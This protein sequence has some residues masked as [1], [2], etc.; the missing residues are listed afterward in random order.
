MCL[1]DAEV[2]QEECKRL[3]GHG[4][5]AIS[6]EAELSRQDVLA[7]AALGHKSLRKRGTFAMGNHPAHD[8]SAE[9][10]DDD[11]Q[12][13]VGPLLRPKQLGYVPAPDLV[14]CSC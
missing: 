14:W 2:G 5:T 12:V 1:V 11:V 9:Y 3:R 13:E 6:M 4:R 7:L 8:V 10:V